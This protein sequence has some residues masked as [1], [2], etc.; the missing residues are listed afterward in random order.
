MFASNK[1]QSEWKVHMNHVHCALR[2]RWFM[3]HKLWAT[4]VYLLHTIWMVI[5]LLP[6]MG[7]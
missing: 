1:D 7:Y 5:K 4:V 2:L 3:N 6:Q